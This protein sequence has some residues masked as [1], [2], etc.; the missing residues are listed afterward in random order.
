MDIYLI[1]LARRPDRRIAMETQARRLGLALTRLD[2]LDARDV[3][4]SAIDRWFQAGGPL[5]E[6]PRGDKCC[7]L[8][9]RAAWEKLVSSGADY[10]AILEDDVAE[11]AKGTP[12]CKSE[13]LQCHVTD[14]PCRHRPSEI[15]KVGLGHL[16]IE[17]F[18]GDGGAP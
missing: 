8:S 5:G 17:G 1:N 16:V 10:A 4:A 18:V 13:H 2:A 7:S 11:L 3:E 6:I 12:F 14:E 9:H 15:G